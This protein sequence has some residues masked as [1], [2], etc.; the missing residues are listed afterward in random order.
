MDTLSENHNTGT[1]TTV[2]L[3]NIYK[4]SGILKVKTKH[5]IALMGKRRR[6]K[7]EQNPEVWFR[8][9]IYQNSWFEQSAGFF[10]PHPPSITNV[11]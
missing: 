11:L 8:V 1:K 7:H 4:T 10:F 9:P 5:T 3:P 2:N 6:P